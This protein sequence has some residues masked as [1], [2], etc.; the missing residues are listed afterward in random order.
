MTLCQSVAL[1]NIQKDN[2]EICRKGQHFKSVVH[3]LSY[4]K[5]PQINHLS[6]IQV[7]RVVYCQLLW[8]K[9]PW[10]IADRQA[11]ISYF[12]RKLSSEYQYWSLSGQHLSLARGPPFEETP[13]QDKIFTALAVFLKYFYLQDSQFDNIHNLKAFLFLG[14]PKRNPYSPWYPLL[15]HNDQTPCSVRSGQQNCI[16]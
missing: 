12:Q 2:S 15:R 6:P 9:R 8:G 3:K 1:Q 16:I 7:S 4:V 10:K 11:Q 14:P 5:D 13:P